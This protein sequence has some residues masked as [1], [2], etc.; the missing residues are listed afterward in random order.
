MHG[1]SLL[2]SAVVVA[3]LWVPV[4]S[5]AA[6]APSA[7]A[8]LQIAID[9]TM[10]VSSCEIEMSGSTSGVVGE[11]IYEAPD[12]WLGPSSA[13]VAGGL[14]VDGLEYA[15]VTSGS[16]LRVVS[17]G[18]ISHLRSSDGLTPA[19]LIA[20]NLLLAARSASAFQAVHGG[21]TFGRSS[22]N[23]ETMG[24][25]IYLSGGRV[26]NVEVNELERGKTLHLEDRFSSFGTA[27]RIRVPARL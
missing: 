25:A 1:F 17:S 21:W 8:L 7:P 19:Q 27:P 4:S 6:L 2:A 20:F 10:S 26:V 22:T 18:P 16:G 15:V 13:R 11:A 23:A 5:A 9:R 12:R 14:I 24:G 3:G